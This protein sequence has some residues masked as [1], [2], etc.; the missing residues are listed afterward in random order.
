MGRTA[1]VTGATRGIG[2]ETVRQLC[3]EGFRVFATGRDAQLLNALGEETGCLGA[4]CDLSDAA[5]TVAPLRSGARCARADRRA[6][7]QCRFQSGE[8]RRGGY[9]H[10][11][12]GRV[13]CRQFPGCVPALPRSDEGRKSIMSR[14]APSCWPFMQNVI[15]KWCRRFGR[16]SRWHRDNR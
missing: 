6:G 15:D 5:A 11:P 16:A 9:Q 14:V 12:D 4:T 2:R 13:V 3:A 8:E 10:R 7:E 1:L